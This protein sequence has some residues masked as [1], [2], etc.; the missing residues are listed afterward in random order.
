MYYSMLVLGRASGRAFEI[1]VF[2]SAFLAAGSLQTGTRF[3]FD[4]E[5]ALLRTYIF[6]FDFSLFH[7]LARFL[8]CQKQM[9]GV[10][11]RACLLFSI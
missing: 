2:Q 7:L 4:F 1:A 10:Q 8:R 5:L 3:D 11:I 9:V 6:A